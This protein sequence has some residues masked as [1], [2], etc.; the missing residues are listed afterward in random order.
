MIGKKEAKR[1]VNLVL[2][3]STADQVEVLIYNHTQALTR[4]AN[5]Y[6]HQNVNESNSAISVRVVF[7][8]KIGTASTN[9]LT[10]EKIKETV[11]WSEEIAKFQKENPDFVSLLSVKAKEY[12]KVKTYIKKTAQ[13]SNI[14]RAEAV[15]E[16]I[17][18]AKRNGLTAYGS[19]SNGIAEV[20]IGNTLGTFAYDIS[21][22][23]FCNIVMSGKN[24]TG[25]AQSGSRDVDE[26]R[27]K[28]LA[29]IAAQKA[30]NSTDPIEIKPGPYTT[31]FEPL[32]VSDFLSY[33]GIYAFNGKL[34]NEG[35]SYLV[36]KLGTKIVDERITIVDDPFRGFAF[37]FDFEG[38][39]KRRLM[40]INKGIAENIV[41]DSLTAV[42]ANTKSTGHALAAPNPY[43]PIPMHMAMKGGD[44]TLIDVIKKTKN[45]LLVT[46]LHYTNIIDPYKLIVTGMTR[47]GTFLVEDGIITKGVKNL[48]FTENI[49][50]ALNRV[51]MI[52]KTSELVAQEPG[53]GARFGRGIYTPVVKIKD[54]AFTSA[55]EF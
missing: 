11:K 25:Y 37:P 28:K 38:F 48:R 51:E 30:I 12:Q 52:S 10:P 7:G 49:I 9:S 26:M 19:V 20:V 47:D 13:F 8:K 17:D 24:S 14:E 27:Y 33:L 39:P 3:E 46:R 53:Y 40:L 1:I 2:K 34:F 41:H 45:G 4:F 31:I 43:G 50:K 22:D 6:I 23:I 32:A 36:G 35:R 15:R 44:A 16:I 42:K 18:V 21:T 55:T 5:N 29:E 54:F